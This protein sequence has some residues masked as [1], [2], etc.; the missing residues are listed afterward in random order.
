MER[1]AAA[2]VRPLV[3]LHLH[4][5][6]E[7]VLHRVLDGDD[8]HPA[9]LNRA[10]HAV[11]RCGL[12]RP[13]RAGHEH[14]SLAGGQQAVD[15]PQ[16]L[17]RHPRRVER[18]RPALLV[19]DADH[20]LL[21][22]R[23]RQRGDSQV[24]GATLHSHAGAAV[25]R[26]E[27]V[28]DVEARHDLDARHQRP[29]DAARQ[30]HGL[31]QDPVDAAADGDAGLLHLEV[32]VTRPRRDGLG[33]DV[34][35][36]AEDGA[37]GLARLPWQ[38]LA[39]GGAV[40]RVGGYAVEQPIDA[41]LRP[42]DLVEPPLDLRRRGEEEADASARGEGKRALAVQVVRVGRRHH[43]LAVA[44]VERQHAVAPRHRLGH[45]LTRPRRDAAER[46]HRHSEA[47]AERLEDLRVTRCAVGDADVPVAVANVAVQALQRGGRQQRGERREQP[48]V[49][50]GRPG[51]VR[52]VGHAGRVTPAHGGVTPAARG[53]GR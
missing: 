33:D 50:D 15:P 37:V 41:G 11:E 53:A 10:Q 27:A 42:V 23:G 17:F 29:A 2:N 19:Q 21:A 5:A 49:V 25:L 28:G 44:R 4:D 12:A 22:V 45:E 9:L 47:G 40:V 35:H 38:L 46:R 26:A 8:V 31:A 32:N 24:D 14:Q 36:E 6:G 3:D 13:G 43:Q 30:R 52:S 34:V 1:S 18:E 51:G 48:A 16:L 39:G 7:A 20:D